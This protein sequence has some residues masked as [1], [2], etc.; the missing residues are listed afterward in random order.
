[1]GDCFDVRSL[2]RF[3]CCGGSMEAGGSRSPPGSSDSGV[4]S[5]SWALGSE[6]GAWSLPSGW[7][8]EG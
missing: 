6:G 5:H 4:A 2:A 3:G 1:M 7:G 8:L